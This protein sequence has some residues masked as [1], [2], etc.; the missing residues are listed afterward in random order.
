[1]RTEQER[2]DDCAKQF[3]TEAARDAVIKAAKVAV[4]MDRITGALCDAVL[5]LRKLEQ[6]DDPVIEL[7]RTTRALAGCLRRNFEVSAWADY[8]T[9]LEAAEKALGME[10]K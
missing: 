10:R 8:E 1:M 4:D 2:V 3:A 7:V 6:P 9:T 5:A